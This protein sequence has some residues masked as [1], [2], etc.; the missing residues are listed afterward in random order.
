[1]DVTA[2][3]SEMEEKFKAEQEKAAADS[4]VEYER[5]KE[6]EMESM[7]QQMREEAAAEMERQLAARERQKEYEMRLKQKLVSEEQLAKI[8]KKIGK[9]G[10][11]LDAADLAK[12]VEGMS[13]S[14]FDN[15]AKLS[16]E[17]KAEMLSNLEVVK[18]GTLKAGASNQR[19]R[20]GS[21]MVQ[22]ALQKQMAEDS[23]L[24]SL[25]EQGQAELSGSGS[26]RGSQT[27]QQALQKQMAEDSE[28]ASL[29][30]QGQG[31]LSG[32][33]SPADVI[34]ALKENAQFVTDVKKLVCTYVQEAVTTAKIPTVDAQ[35][36]W[37]RYEIADLSVAEIAI[38]PNKLVL[39]VD[40]S[41]KVQISNLRATFDT[42][43][44]VL[45]KTTTPKINDKGTGT[46]TMSGFSV[47]VS[48]DIVSDAETGLGVKFE[49]PVVSLESLDVKVNDCK[50][51]WIF[52]KLLKWCKTK[53]QDAVVK[54]IQ[55]QAEE[56]V[57]TLAAQLSTLIATIS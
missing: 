50:N 37:G 22:Q 10:E 38:D 35:K 21:Q 20:R 13:V 11:K 18:K 57:D 53:V 25:M 16:E 51:E 2:L 9:P 44:W 30:E 14:V 31:V 39:T 42:F 49:P 6:A 47:V 56:K 15:F 1:M 3:K 41:V 26:R 28:L 52:N 8:A 55:T 17:E 48:F 7:M 36:D 43:R 23:E 12:T 29:M 45:E 54:E 4:Q 27:V 40:K 24:A 34:T 5:K 19:V 32:S 46:A 33:G